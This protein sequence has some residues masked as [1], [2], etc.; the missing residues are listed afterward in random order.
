MADRKTSRSRNNRRIA[1]ATCCSNRSTD[2]RIAK[3]RLVIY[4]KVLV[5]V[6]AWIL[7]KTNI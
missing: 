5:R 7:L 1:A 2:R 4:K 6:G 3:S